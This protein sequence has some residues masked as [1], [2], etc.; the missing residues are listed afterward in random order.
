M[1]IA[2]AQID[3]TVGDIEGNLQRCLDAAASADGADVVL[4]P[5]LALTGYPPEDLLARAG[6]VER[7]ETALAR[8]AAQAIRPCVAGCVIRSDRGLHNAAAYL[9]DGQVRAVYH[10]RLLPNYG[11][12][13]EERYFEPGQS[14][15]IVDIAGVKC[16]LT[17]C[18]DIWS[19]A[20]V[21]RVAAAGAQAVLNI[22]ASPFHRGKG[23]EREEML[24][25][26]ASESGVWVAYCNLVGGQDELVFDG[27]S[28]L[29]APDG[30]L[31]VRAAAFTEDVASFDIA[32]GVIRAGSL[33][34]SPEGPEEV[35]RAL[36]LGLGDY[37][38]KNGFADVVLGLSGGVDSALVATVAVDALG[39]DHVHGVLLPGPY[40]SEGSVRDALELAANLGIATHTLPIDAPHR[41][42]LDALEPA[43]GRLERTLAEEN[44]QARIRG[45]MLMALS[46]ANGWLVLVT[47]NKS[48]LAVGYSTLYGDMAG[49]YAPI[50]DVFKTHVYD[51]ARWRNTVSP[52]VPEATLHKPPSAELRP[53][54]TDQDSLP[55]YDVLDAVLLGYIE[56]DRSVDDLVAHGHDPEVVERVVRMVD[57]AEYKRRQAA[58]GTR[59]TAKAFG[60]DRRMPITNAYRG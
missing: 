49:G 56:E 40:S 60:R 24:R 38:R 17:V 44:L 20:T 58:P 4:L 52:A 3:V 45:T 8:L 5:E 53:D 9:A 33:R 23:C 6:F 27:R 10:K 13:D 1:R 22:S 31:A 42:L 47:G 48:E 7:S 54:Q 12:F 59:V 26:R 57:A 46:N 51:I 11:V 35:H 32:P 43:A 21:E 37:C 19:S 55:P 41:A 29:F 39:A 14:D 36:V 28:M 15:V 18:E 16:A 30:T 50:K 2:L 34:P 25:A